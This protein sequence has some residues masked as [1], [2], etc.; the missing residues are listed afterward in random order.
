MIDNTQ[1]LDQIPS[2]VAL[3]DRMLEGLLEY[4]AR[5]RF[6]AERAE[7]LPNETI[8]AETFNRPP[9]SNLLITYNLYHRTDLFPCYFP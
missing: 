4:I 9:Q 8:L 6:E 2:S 1:Y 5:T 3:V 7:G